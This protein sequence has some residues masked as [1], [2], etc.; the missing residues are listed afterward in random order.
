MKRMIYTTIA[1][2]GLIISAT[3]GMDISQIYTLHTKLEAQDRQAQQELANSLLSIEQMITLRQRVYNPANLGDPARFLATH[4]IAKGMLRALADEHQKRPEDSRPIVPQSPRSVAEQL[5]DEPLEQD[6]STAYQ[7]A[8]HALGMVQGR[9]SKDILEKIISRYTGAF[10][11][12]AATHPALYATA[13]CWAVSCNSLTR[14]ERQCFDDRCY[15][16]C[17]QLLA[18]Y[19]Q[20]QRRSCCTVL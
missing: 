19:K 14:L 6:G 5:V 11:I 10:T 4:Y 7:G 15:S 13:L 18:A 17:A 2:A 1:L 3:R 8:Q 9:M 12:I 20:T 16:D